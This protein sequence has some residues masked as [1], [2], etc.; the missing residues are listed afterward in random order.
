[1]NYSH[2][3]HL[4]RITVSGSNHLYI[5]HNP[6]KPEAPSELPAEIDWDFAQKEI[7]QAKGFA[8]DDR[9]GLSKGALWGTER[10]RRKTVS[11]Q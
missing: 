5:F 8:T 2:D 4:S 1:M 11:E 3:F 6:L 7:A 9:A 10:G